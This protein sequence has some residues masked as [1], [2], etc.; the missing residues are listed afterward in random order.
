[1]SPPNSLH[2]PGK[3]A[4][5]L[6]SGFKIFLSASILLLGAVG[7][8]PFLREKVAVPIPSPQVERIVTVPT[9][10]DNVPPPTVSVTIDTLPNKT[11]P[12]SVAENTGK[13][14]HVYPEPILVSVA[15]LLKAELCP[16]EIPK[17][18]STVKPVAVFVRE[19]ASIHPFTTST[20]ALIDKAPTTFDKRPE[21]IDPSKIADA[22]LPMFHFAE[23]M[24]PLS[25]EKGERTPP[26]NPFQHG[27]K[28][29]MPL[30]VFAEL[31]PLRLQESP[32]ITSENGS[33]P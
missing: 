6:S 32:S 25:S 31:R 11:V 14:A 30:R 16:S 26:E 4:S 22:L 17:V 10:V 12:P 2:R 28:K 29:F 18:E 19:F 33:T 27:G 9:S 1:M 8:L 24:K 21:S 13:V 20:T 7:A 5:A 3:G 15:P 23:N